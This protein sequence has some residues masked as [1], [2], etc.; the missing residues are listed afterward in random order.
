MKDEVRRVAFRLVGRRLQLLPTGRSTNR[1][2][3]TQEPRQS[4][5]SDSVSAG[6]SV[7]AQLA[8]VRGSAQRI[9]ISDFSLGDVLV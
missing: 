3:G 4:V 1:W 6:G 7:S 9:F 5:N 8:G 2:W